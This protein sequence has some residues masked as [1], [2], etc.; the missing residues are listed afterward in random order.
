MLSLDDA[1]VPADESVDVDAEL[2][3]DEV[4]RVIVRGKYGTV[5]LFVGISSVSSP[6][7]VSCAT[8]FDVP[9]CMITSLPSKS[10]PPPTPESALSFEMNGIDA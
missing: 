7:A 9:L 4:G 10:D 1:V 5:L 6:V 2:E 3:E 8:D